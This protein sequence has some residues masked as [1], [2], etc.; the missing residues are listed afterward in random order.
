[1]AEYSTENPEPLFSPEDIEWL[2]RQAEPND[3]KVSA[4]LD[5]L[6]RIRTKLESLGDLANCPSC[7]KLYH[8]KMYRMCE[9]CKNKTYRDAVATGERKAKPKQKRSR[10]YIPIKN[11]IRSDWEKLQ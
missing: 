8:S 3:E 2:I 5:S 9:G 6:F 7:G 10:E 11:P 1:V 4:Y